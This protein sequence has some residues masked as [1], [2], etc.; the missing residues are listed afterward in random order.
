M[1]IPFFGLVLQCVFI[2]SISILN[3]AR[4]Y[5]MEHFS[6]YPV[7]FF[8]LFLGV[9]S[10]ICGL[11]GLIKKVNIGLSSLVIVMGLLICFFFVFAYLLGE[12]GTPPPIRWFY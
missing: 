8:E 11:L 6:I 5:V 10:F 2:L 1:N 3:F 9:A 4:V 12:A 7:A